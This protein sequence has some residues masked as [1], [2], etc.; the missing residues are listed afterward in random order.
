[1]RTWAT[2]FGP[3]DRVW[4]DKDKSITGVV[5]GIWIVEDRKTF[6]VEW[7]ANGVAYEKCFDEFRLTHAKE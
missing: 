4:I 6:N 1:M 5:T 2:E 7:F 3:G